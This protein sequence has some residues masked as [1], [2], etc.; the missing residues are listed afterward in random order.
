MDLVVAHHPGWDVM[1]ALGLPILVYVG[2]RIWEGR[3]GPPAPADGDDGTGGA[4][5]AAGRAGDDP[6]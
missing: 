4:D 5:A 1:F 6:G 3:K 2:L